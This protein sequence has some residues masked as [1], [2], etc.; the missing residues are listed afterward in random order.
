[1]IYILGFLSDC[2]Y[3]RYQ[4]HT[5]YFGEIAFDLVNEKIVNPAVGGQFENEDDDVENMAIAGGALF[6]AVV[7]RS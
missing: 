4:A 5:V 6:T 2:R 7:D 1:M 3:E